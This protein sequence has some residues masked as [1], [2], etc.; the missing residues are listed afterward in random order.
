MDFQPLIEPVVINYNK[1]VY[2]KPRSNQ[3]D[4]ANSA[5]AVAQAAMQSMHK[6]Q[7]LISHL[8]NH[9]KHE[10]SHGIVNGIDSAATIN[11]NGGGNHLDS[12]VSSGLKMLGNQIKVYPTPDPSKFVYDETSGN[13]IH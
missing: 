8:T 10:W 5:A 3:A 9:M 4:Q 1:P 12:S 2:E 13:G 11:L 7:E 6:K